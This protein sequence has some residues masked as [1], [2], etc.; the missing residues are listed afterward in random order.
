MENEENV[1]VCLRIIIELHKQFRPQMSLEIQKFL[2]FVKN[3]YHELPKHMAKIFEP[4]IPIKVALKVFCYPGQNSSCDLYPFLSLSLVYTFSQVK[5]INELQLNLLLQ[6]TYTMTQ[7]HFEKKP[8]G[9]GTVNLI[10][11][12]TLSLKVLLGTCFKLL[13]IQL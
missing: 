4:R 10:P 12:A 9:E 13:G 6:E 1:L 11:R 3:I 2:V 5:D 8:S 7:I